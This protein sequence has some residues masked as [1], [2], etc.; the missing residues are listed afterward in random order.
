MAMEK[1]NK[2]KSR[3]KPI[4][5]ESSLSLEEPVRPDEIIRKLDR[6]KAVELS[7]SIPLMVKVATLLGKGE[8]KQSVKKK[9]GLKE[10]TLKSW[11]TSKIFI[12]A[13]NKA[14][15]K[16][17]AE[18]RA[19]MEEVA[20]KNKLAA[21]G[22]DDVVG[23]LLL[24]LRKIFKIP[25]TLWEERGWGEQYTPEEREAVMMLMAIYGSVAMVHRVTGISKETLYRW[26]SRLKVEDK[27]TY[28][29]LRE[30]LKREF[31]EEFMRHAQEALKRYFEQLSRPS[32]VQSADSKAA[33]HVVDRLLSAYMHAYN[34]ASSSEYDGTI[35]T[36]RDITRDM[37]EQLS[38]GDPE[39]RDRIVSAIE[40]RMRRIHPSARVRT[41]S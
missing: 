8:S 1:K 29:K 13:F 23:P 17:I 5:T 11:V 7:R 4:S 37:V 21:V 38:S 27:E 25:K 40:E 34:A 16:A 18:R 30:S 33:I 10:A 39:A 35:E 24:P 2:K 28:G 20:R 12:R 14:R 26:R 31:L 36:G 6:D 9:F 41:G 19:R 15:K 3:P 32:V 22:A